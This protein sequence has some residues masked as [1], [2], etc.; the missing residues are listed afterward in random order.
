MK[1]SIEYCVVWD[2]FPKAASL[3]DSLHKEFESIDIEFI[4]GSGGIFDV[5]KEGGIIFSKHKTGRFPGEDEIIKLL[6]W[7]V[8]NTQNSSE[9][10]LL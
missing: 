5:K 2:Y 3:A 6:K 1:V 9:L 8:S 7:K 10:F 4:K